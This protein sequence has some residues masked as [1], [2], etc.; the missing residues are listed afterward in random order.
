MYVRSGVQPFLNE[1]LYRQN[2]LN[3]K[4]NETNSIT[5]FEKK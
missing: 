3:I 5:L 4:I 2:D 1:F